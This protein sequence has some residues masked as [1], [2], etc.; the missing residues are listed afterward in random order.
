MNVFEK[1]KLNVAISNFE[2][3]I[4]TPNN[5]RIYTMKKR[6]IALACTGLVLVSSIVVCAHFENIK[7]YFGGVDKGIQSAA[8]NGYISNPEM[9]YAK[10]DVVVENAE[11]IIDNMVA[12][13]KIEDFM[14]DDL[15]INLEFS[16][17]FDDKLK[18]VFNLDE[19]HN[20]ELMNLLVI[21]DE[22]NIIYGA[23]ED[24]VKEYCNKI[25]LEY[26]SDEFNQKF[27]NSGLSWFPTYF[28][29]KNGMVNFTYNMYSDLYPKSKKLNFMF[30]KVKLTGNDE[31]DIIVTGDWNLEIDVPEKMY[32]RTSEAYRVVSCDNKDFEVY[33]CKVSETSFEIGVLISNI[34]EPQ[35]PLT[36][37]EK[38]K[39]YTINEDVESGKISIEEATKIRDKFYKYMDDREPIAISPNNFESQNREVSFVENSE[40]KKFE[41]TMSPGRKAECNFI[42][43]DKCNFYETFSMTK[44]DSTDKIKVV[45]YYYGTPV[46]IELEKVK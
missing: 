1:F 21:D 37:E 20:I 30:N 44:Y 14:M 27:C 2:N 32:N 31:N 18:D 7:K 26:D 12:E 16:F 19:L 13:M 46:T 9:D 42:A 43:G 35:Y 3:D 36:E 24:V 6:V 39:M 15:N 45:L 28:N 23:T 4:N 17:K 8:E 5:R 25:N 33:S 38:K 22:E 40:G 29:S 10:S 34:K 41:C 11:K